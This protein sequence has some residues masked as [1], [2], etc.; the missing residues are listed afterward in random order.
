VIVARAGR[1]TASWSSA[2]SAV[3]GS[4]INTFSPFA[5]SMR[6][7]ASMSV[8]ADQLAF[9]VV[10]DRVPSGVSSKIDR[11]GR[12][13]TGEV[14]HIR[15]A[16]I[17]DTIKLVWAD[18]DAHGLLLLGNAVRM[19]PTDFSS[20][21]TT[22]LSHQLGPAPSPRITLNPPL[23]GRMAPTSGGRETHCS[24]GMPAHRAKLGG[25]LQSRRSP[26]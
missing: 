7:R 22:T 23:L 20:K 3:A 24:C 25:R 4:S 19:L 26:S 1:A 17:A 10:T 5:S 13:A 14:Q 11:T 21:A 9:G 18:L 16:V 15:V 6:R 2:G 12:I 8:K